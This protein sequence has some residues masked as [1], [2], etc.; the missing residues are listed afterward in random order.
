MNTAH[1]QPPSAKDLVK[2]SVTVPPEEWHGHGRE[3]RWAEALGGQRY[4]LQNIP[5]FAY[6]LSLLDVIQINAAEAVQTIEEAGH[7]TYRVFIKD[8]FTLRAVEL[9]DTMTSL[10]T[11]Y[12]RATASLVAIDVPPETDIHKVF[13]V[14]EGGT[15]EGVWDFEEAHVEHDLTR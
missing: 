10:G 5:F 12:E 1:D 9:L 15:L 14:L 2:I 11:S 6:G 7:S 3:A 8:A 4:R 13:A